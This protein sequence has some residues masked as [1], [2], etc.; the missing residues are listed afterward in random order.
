MILIGFAVL[1]AVLFLGFQLIAI[2]VGLMSSIGFMKVERYA[3]IVALFLATSATVVLEL[4]RA[5]VDMN[6]VV[7]SQELVGDWSLE[8][9]QLQ[10]SEK[11]YTL[12]Y[13]DTSHTGSWKLENLDLY[14]S[15]DDG[16]E[17]LLTVFKLDD[18]LRLRVD[19]DASEVDRLFLGR[20]FKRD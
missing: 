9:R 1:T 7:T 4:T 16:S 12:K 11:T 3:A 13:D 8:N 10:L 2:P 20:S 17:E 14:L 19:E 6:P 18:N 5:D 15:K